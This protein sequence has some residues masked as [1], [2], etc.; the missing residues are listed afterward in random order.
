MNK[1]DNKFNEVFASTYGAYTG[2][3]YGISYK[4]TLNDGTII[5]ASNWQWDDKGTAII[6]YVRIEREVKAVKG[7]RK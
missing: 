7:R 2:S 5:Q 6:P 1:Y 3:R 4:M